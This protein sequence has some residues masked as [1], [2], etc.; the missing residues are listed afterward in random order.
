M[1][2]QLIVVI[3]SFILSMVLKPQ[4]EVIGQGFGLSGL[5]SWIVP[6]LIVLLC[7]WKIGSDKWNLG[8]LIAS[9]VL[10]VLI[11]MYFYQDVS[12]IF[13]ECSRIMLGACVGAIV[14]YSAK[15]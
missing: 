14:A 6:T 7:V 11:L 1:I 8:D 15:K 3:L 5:L 2:N 12:Q 13:L 9:F 10:I 4:V